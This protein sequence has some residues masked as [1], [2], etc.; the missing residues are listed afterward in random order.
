MLRAPISAAITQLRS[1]TLGARRSRRCARPIYL[2]LM[3]HDGQ[4]FRRTKMRHLLGFAKLRN[5]AT[6]TLRTTSAICTPMARGSQ[7]TG[8]PDLRGCIRRRCRQRHGA[9]SPRIA[10][11]DGRERRRMT[12]GRSPGFASPPSKAMPTL[13]SGR[14]SYDQ[15]AACRRI[16]PLRSCGIAKAPIRKWHGQYAVG[17]MYYKSWRSEGF[18]ASVSLVHAVHCT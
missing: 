10:Y 3:Y 18:G 1:A 7:K 16:T 13:S 2:G 4:A 14:L 12:L 5:K 6:P 11:V 17:L 9:V 15:A 8:L